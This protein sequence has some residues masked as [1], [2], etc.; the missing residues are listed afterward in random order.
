MVDQ[1]EKLAGEANRKQQAYHL[2]P[3]NDCIANCNGSERCF[4]ESQ[5]SMIAITMLLKQTP[6]K[7]LTCVEG[8]LFL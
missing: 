2:E 4:Y 7:T 3:T 8:A 6:D 5:R 1:Q